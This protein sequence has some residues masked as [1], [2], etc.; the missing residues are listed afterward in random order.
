[1]PSQDYCRSSATKQSKI[2]VWVFLLVSF[3]KSDLGTAIAFVARGTSLPEAAAFLT[4]SLIQHG[5]SLQH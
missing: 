2:V 1:M 3:R 4:V 5:R